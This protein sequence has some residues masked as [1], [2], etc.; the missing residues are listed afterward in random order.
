M[1]DDTIHNA[2]N[3]TAERV[4]GSRIGQKLGLT[5]HRRL[6]FTCLGVSGL[7]L[8]PFFGG[9]NE[10]IFR[11]T[12]IL[13]GYTAAASTIR[14]ITESISQTSVK[15]EN[16]EAYVLKLIRFPFL[17][18]GISKIIV[19]LHRSLIAE[20]IGGALCLAA[21]SAAIYLASSSNGMLDRA[22]DC[23]KE[24]WKATRELAKK[25]KDAVA[26]VADGLIH[27]KPAPKPQP[28]EVR[29]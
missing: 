29:D 14:G 21:I 5:T 12:I 19:G 18:Y 2:V 20:R 25:A 9:S 1:V 11:G 6:A 16:I 26:D 8:F 7:S 3:R 17:L 4:E 10:T 28:V 13:L 24:T 15:A 23:A 27:P 22:K